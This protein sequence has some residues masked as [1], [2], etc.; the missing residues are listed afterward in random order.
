MGKACTNIIFGNKN[1]PLN[2]LEMLAKNRN[3]MR[4]QKF[5]KIKKTIKINKNSS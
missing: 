2:P 5:R 3:F 4:N 1:G